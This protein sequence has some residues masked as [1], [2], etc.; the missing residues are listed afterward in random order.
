MDIIELK[1]HEQKNYKCK[2]LR[3][4]VSECSFQKEKKLVKVFKIVGNHEFEEIMSELKIGL[5]TEWD[6][7][8]SPEEDPDSD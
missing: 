7:L 8:L 3:P 1:N 2:T 5:V 4:Y 6:E